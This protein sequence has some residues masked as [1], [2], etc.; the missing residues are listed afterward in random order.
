MINQEIFVVVGGKLRDPSIIEFSDPSAL[1]L[2]GSFASYDEAKAVWRGEAQK[3]VDDALMRYFIV[4][5]HKYLV[6]E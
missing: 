5:L 2:V 4:P 1:H 3:T 6:V